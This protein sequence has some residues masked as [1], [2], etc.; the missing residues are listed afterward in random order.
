MIYFARAAVKECGIS[1]NRSM[2]KAWRRTRACVIIRPMETIKRFLQLLGLIK[3]RRLREIQSRQN[4]CAICSPEKL[5]TWQDFVA[6]IDLLVSSPDSPARGILN[7]IISRQNS[8]NA[9]RLTFFGELH[10]SRSDWAEILRFA[11]LPIQFAAET[12]ELLSTEFAKTQTF[13][14]QIGLINSCFQAADPTHVEMLFLL[15]EGNVERYP[16][17]HTSDAEQLVAREM[18]ARQKL[19]ALLNQEMNDELRWWVIRTINSAS[20]PAR[21]FLSATTRNRQD[22]RLQCMLL[23][24]LLKTGFE[25]ATKFGKASQ[26]E[27]ESMQSHLY[28]SRL[29]EM[30]ELT[31]PVSGS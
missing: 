25:W 26:D 29:T 14:Q 10:A 2:R 13:H 8:T 15:I 27:I 19:A 28:A 12:F 5:Q 9:D 23:P 4:A 30:L 31:A 3:D 18:A 20:G 17:P 11:D 24:R 7:A 22:L 6:Y 21:R 16:Q 1:E